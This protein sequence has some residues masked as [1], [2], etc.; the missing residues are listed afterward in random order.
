MFLVVFLQNH[1]KPVGALW[2]HWSKLNFVYSLEIIGDGRFPSNFLGIKEILQD[3]FKITRNRKK[4]QFTEHEN[5]LN[6]PQSIIVA[7]DKFKSDPQGKLGYT[8]GTLSLSS[9]SVGLSTKRQLA[10]WLKAEGI[11]FSASLFTGYFT[12]HDLVSD[13]MLYGLILATVVVDADF[14]KKSFK[15]CRQASP[16]GHHH[17]IILTAVS[18]VSLRGTLTHRNSTPVTQTLK[19]VTLVYVCVY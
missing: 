11:S 19:N 17:N 15:N 8:P 5:T 1:I 4:R 10:I 16:C 12:L 6:Y 7:S 13:I 14:W 18:Q 9:E 2:R 3:C